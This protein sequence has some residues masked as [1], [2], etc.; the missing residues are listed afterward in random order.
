MIPQIQ[1]ISTFITKGIPEIID[2]GIQNAVEKYKNELIDYQVNRQWFDAGEKADG[3]KI[4][5]LNK[6][7]K[8]YSQFTVRL[9]KPKGQPTDRVTWKDTGR[10]H[11]SVRILV[12]EDRFIIEVDQSRYND[13]VKQYGEGGIGIQDIYLRQ[14]ANDRII[15]E[16]KALM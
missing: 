7:Y 13:L 14:F 10:F 5:P 3:S 2:K 11:S 1:E 4:T 9:K 12:L 15:P 8:V 16:I 6:P